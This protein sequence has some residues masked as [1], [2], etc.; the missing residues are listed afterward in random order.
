MKILSR[1]TIPCLILSASSAV[2]A[3]PFTCGEYNPTAAIS[4]SSNLA[5]TATAMIASPGH[6]ILPGSFSEAGWFTSDPFG[7]CA[8][9]GCSPKK[10][11]IQGWSQINSYNKNGTL[12]QVVAQRFNSSGGDPLTATLN[13]TYKPN[14][15]YYLSTAEN[16]CMSIG[17]EK[18]KF[19]FEYTKDLLQAI[20]LVP[21]SGCP[22][23]APVNISFKYEDS[24]V[25]KLPTSMVVNQQGKDP[26]TSTYK[27][28][29]KEGKI[30]AYAITSPQGNMQMDVGYKK[31]L[32]SSITGSGIEN[33][34]T[35]RNSSQ[36]ASMIDPRY[37][38]GL[39]IDYY[40]TDKIE[41][42][43]QNTGWPGAQADHFYY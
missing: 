34:I 26:E 13:F 2:A 4:P 38:W 22:S 36:W 27:Y 29:I 37:N 6:P 17:A 39:T 12:K 7:T 28:I 24:N 30:T 11:V 10:S 19:T 43:L 20:K 14:N 3:S 42:T 21:D 31:D 8:L 9:M 41:S 35:Y 15:P 16:F 32:I 25:P 40:S 18:V 23:N 5:L 1:F 33:N